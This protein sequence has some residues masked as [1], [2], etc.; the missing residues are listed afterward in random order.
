MISENRAIN[1]EVAAGYTVEASSAAIA[2][3]WSHWHVLYA[4]RPERV[5]ASMTFDERPFRQTFALEGS[6]WHARGFGGEG[7]WWLERA[8]IGVQRG[9]FTYFTRARCLGIPIRAETVMEYERVNDTRISYQGKGIAALPQTFR[10]LHPILQLLGSRITV[11]INQ[12]GGQVAELITRDPKQV[13]RTVNEDAFQAYQAFMDEERGIRAG[14]KGPFKIFTPENSSKILTTED[15]SSVG[16][17]DEM[18]RLVRMLERLELLLQS[19]HSQ[20][21]WIDDYRASLTVFSQDHKLALVKNRMIVTRIAEII[22]NKEVGENRRKL[23]LAER[24]SQ[25][26][27]KS[28]N[29]PETI[30]SIM[31]FVDSLGDEASR[32]SFGGLFD[33]NLYAISF[34]STLQITEWFLVEYLAKGEAVDHC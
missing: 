7:E 34:Q 20:I 15:S 25:L 22:Y 18:S 17:S 9:R 33:S 29:V 2:F 1:F 4:F 10:L 26:Q 14:K 6:R 5:R 11:H 13:A 16:P 21:A 8:E 30:L 28:L 23:S 24:L 3:L 32:D 31:R 27:Q 19:L 12:I